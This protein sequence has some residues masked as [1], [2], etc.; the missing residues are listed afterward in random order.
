MSPLGGFLDAL[1][2]MSHLSLAAGPAD[3]QTSEQKNALISISSSKGWLVL[4]IW[5]GCVHVYKAVKL[6]CSAHYWG[7]LLYS[8][9]H[10]SKSNPGFQGLKSN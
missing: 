6:D 10:S 5:Q 2:I 9:G 8:E 4:R 7:G 1:K 3:C